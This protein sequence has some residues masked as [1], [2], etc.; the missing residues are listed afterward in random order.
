[1]GLVLSPLLSVPI[2]QDRGG[3]F[4]RM[5]RQGITPSAVTAAISHHAD[6][7]SASCSVGVAA[8]PTSA[9]RAATPIAMPVWRIMFTTP[10]PVAKEDCG[11]EAAA[12]PIKVGS[13]RP[14]PT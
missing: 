6:L 12:V 13:V 10:D 9:T 8:A 7:K 5:Y 3:H 14:T 2:L 11:S 4:R 1:M